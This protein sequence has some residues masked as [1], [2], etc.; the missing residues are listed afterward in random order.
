MGV[1]SRVRSNVRA[2]REVNGLIRLEL[3]NGLMRGSVERQWSLWVDKLKMA[4]D[5]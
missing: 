2:M 5:R 4:E 3:V 1:Q